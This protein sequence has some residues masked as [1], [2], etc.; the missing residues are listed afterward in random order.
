MFHD[1]LVDFAERRNIK[2]NQLFKIHFFTL[3]KSRINIVLCLIFTFMI[4]FL[5]KICLELSNYEEMEVSFNL[6]ELQVII[7]L[8]VLLCLTFFYYR[9][10]K[11]KIFLQE[12]MNGKSLG[13]MF[14]SRIIVLE[15][16]ML[17]LIA[18]FHFILFL[19]CGQI[20][21]ENPAFFL[22]LGMH[23]VH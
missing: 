9:Q 21:I 10:Q 17:V 3:I 8:W 1:I 15:L 23:C 22:M 20:S 12:K 2:M 19:I 7:F 14:F 11:N 6:G 4:P 16:W 13:E 18:V 5:L